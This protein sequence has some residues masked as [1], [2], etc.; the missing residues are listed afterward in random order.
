MR[1]GGHA[2]ERPTLERSD[3]R[4]MQ[5][6]FGELEIAEQANECCEDT[7]RVGP[8]D[9]IDPLARLALI[10]LYGCSNS[11]IGRTSTEPSRADGIRAATWIASFKSFALIR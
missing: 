4:I 2:F 3:E 6:F 11:M 9:R 10:I 8:I 1:I 5:C 7:A